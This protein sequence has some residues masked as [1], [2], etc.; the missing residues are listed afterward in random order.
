MIK[1]YEKLASRFLSLVLC[2]Y[3]MYGISFDKN[4]RKCSIFVCNCGKAFKFLEFPF[5][6]ITLQ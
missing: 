1:M 4:E 6:E 5:S 2:F 3:R